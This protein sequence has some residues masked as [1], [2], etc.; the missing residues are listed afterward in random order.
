M[1]PTRFPTYLAD[2]IRQSPGPMVKDVRTFQESGFTKVPYGLIVTFATGAEAYIHAV[3][4]SETKDNFDKPEQI[5]EGEAAIE[6]WP[7][8]EG[9]GASGKIKLADVEAWL[10]A[11]FTS[12]GSREIS[13]IEAWSQRED[14]RPDHAGVTAYFHSGARIFAAVAHLVG[15]GQST[16]RQQWYEPSQEV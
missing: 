10:A 7:Y 11:V 15:P 4:A 16:D 5:V 8:P 14:G 13:R 3:G 1:R 2:V 12:S 6:P 9:L